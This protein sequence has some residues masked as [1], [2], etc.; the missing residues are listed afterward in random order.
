MKKHI[1]WVSVLA[2]AFLLVVSACSSLQQDVVISSDELIH[3][4]DVL[5]IETTLAKIDSDAIMG[6][7]AENRVRLCT[8]LLSQIDLALND[9]GIKKALCS[10]L[11]ALQGR[12]Y[13]L[14]G[15]KTEA[16]TCYNESVKASRGDAQAIVLGSRLGLVPDIEDRNVLAGSNQRTLLVLERGLQLF[17]EGAYLDSLAKLDEAFLSLDSFYKVAYKNVRDTAWSLRSVSTTGSS[18]QNLLLSKSVSVSNMAAITQENT[19]LLNA[20]TGGKTLSQTELVQVLVKAG[21]LSPVSATVTEDMIPSASDAATR[22]MCA[23]FLWNL[24]VTKRN[25]RKLTTRYSQLYRDSSEPS[26][27]P[28]VS[29][30]S[31]DFDAV[32]GCVENEIM[33][34]VDGEHFAPNQTVSGVEFNTWVSRIK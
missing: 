5:A 11:Y 28:D 4:E 3:Q 19:L 6:L 1:A 16:R 26:P 10:R 27:I 14:M 30:D 33:E 21:L 34:L 23:R 12:T 17:S 29:V 7:N 31:P 9:A 22:I 25:N 2:S 32:L 15:K 24:Y 18:V 20:Y 8:M 13:L